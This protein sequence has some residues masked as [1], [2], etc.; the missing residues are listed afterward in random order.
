MEL[1]DLIAALV[2]LVMVVIF[3][4]RDARLK[5]QLPPKP[6]PASSKTSPPVRKPLK[7]ET[8]R[9]NPVTVK[10]D[11]APLKEKKIDLGSLLQDRGNLQKAFILQEILKRYDDLG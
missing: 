4:K 3:I 11:E 2:T 5:K 8:L 7:V 1:K 10:V 6:T 9:R